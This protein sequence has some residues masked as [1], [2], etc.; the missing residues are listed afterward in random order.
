MEVRVDG[1]AAEIEHQITYLYKCEIYLDN[2]S[3]LTPLIAFR[4]VGAVVVSAACEYA[5]AFAEHTLC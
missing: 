4:S 1:D 5:I 3:S 2:L